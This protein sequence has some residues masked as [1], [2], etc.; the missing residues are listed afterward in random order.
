MILSA[1]LQQYNSIAV[2][3]YRLVALALGASRASSLSFIMPATL[4]DF[5]PG[6]GFLLI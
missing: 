4:P 3:Q 6:Y 5:H 2:P 1:L